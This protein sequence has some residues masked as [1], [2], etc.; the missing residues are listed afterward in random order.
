MDWTNRHL[1]AIL[2]NALLEDRA[3][4]DATSYAC[5]EPNQ[6]AAATVL[7]KQECILA[8]IGVIRLVFENEPIMPNGVFDLSGLAQRIDEPIHQSRRRGCQ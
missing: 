3:T 4:R 1:N 5:V 6:K 7:A 8:G 2:Q